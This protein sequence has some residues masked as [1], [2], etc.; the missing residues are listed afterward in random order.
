VSS[1]NVGQGGS[2]LSG[3]SC[4]SPRSCVA[5]GFYG[6]AHGVTV[7]TL[8]ESWNGS[9][10]KIVA[11]PNSATPYSSLAA[12][13]CLSSTLCT[14]VGSDGPN[15]NDALV[16][17]WNGTSWK[18]VPGP[19]KGTY[20]NAL[21]SV[22]CVSVSFCAAVGN[23]SDTG[24]PERT[25]V[26]LWNGRNWRVVASPNQGTVSDFLDSVSCVS[27]S[28]CVATGNAQGSAQTLIESWDGRSWRLAQSPSTGMIE[29]ALY[30]VSC[31]S[32][33]WCTAV[34]TF[35]PVL[36]PSSQWNETLAV[37][38]NGSSWKLVTVPNPGGENASDVFSSVSCPSAISC[39]AVGVYNQAG[40]QDSLIESWNG[41]AWS[42]TPSPNGL[43]QFPGSSLTNVFCVSAISCKAVGGYDGFNKQGY[44][45]LKTVIDTYS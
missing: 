27:A 25:L 38:W 2:G 15:V 30:G 10:W 24:Q 6:G 34:G 7:G 41:T 20:D 39:Q 18:I 26:E 45:I 44:S 5:V 12:V 4:I 32:A 16:E 14:A 17:S 21:R 33:T 28:W 37:V 40:E 13:S 3:V 22:S 35:G 43:P 1:P 42:I 9:S 23:Y 29:N 8:I 36:E 19:N 31:A 11:S